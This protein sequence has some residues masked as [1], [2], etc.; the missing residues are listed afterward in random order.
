MADPTVYPVREFAP[1]E[2]PIGDVLDENGELRLRHDVVGKDYFTIQLIG[3]RVR[4]QARGFVGLIPLN[5]RICIDVEPRTP[6]NNLARLLTIARQVP[7]APVGV[8]SYERDPVWSES[9]LETYAHGLIGRIEEIASNGLL[10]EYERRTEATS[11]PRGRILAGATVRQLHSRGIDHRV[12]ASHYQREDDNAA[13]RCLKYALWFIAKR[14]RLQQPLKGERRKLLNR[15]APLYELFADVPLET[16]T[17]FL[18]DPLVTGSRQLPS[19]RSYYR[20]ALDLAAAIVEQHGVKLETREGPI[21]LP[22]VILDMST[23][24]EDYLRNLLLAESQRRGWSQRV[25]D[26]NG[27]GGTLLF[28][29]EPSEK[30]TPDIVF[31]ERAENAE[32][33]PLLIEVKSSPVKKLH[34]DRSSIAQ[35]VTYGVSY[36]CSHVVLAHPRKSADTFCGLRTQGTLGDLTLHQYVFDL[37]ADS[38]ED[39]ER[40]FATAMEGLL[41]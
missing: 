40:R 29:E 25:L 2:V 19:S 13:N 4:L 28:D 37:A 10:R 38:I 35:A 14:L 16:S 36:R 26:G 6:A 3:G 34:S 24:F 12:I 15:A 11:F 9:L 27:E 32:R 17:G 31:R 8:A 22:S 1:A 7:Q 30:A 23:L 18:S 20:P 5:E 39:E 21:Q 33:Y 41:G